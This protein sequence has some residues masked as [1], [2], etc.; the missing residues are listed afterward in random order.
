MS[1]HPRQFWQNAFDAAKA[2]GKCDFD[3]ARA[4]DAALTE[5]ADWEVVKLTVP[6]PVPVTRTCRRDG[7]TCT[8]RR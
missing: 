4:A 3:A 7:P 2:T 6:L 1:L 5:A 8:Y